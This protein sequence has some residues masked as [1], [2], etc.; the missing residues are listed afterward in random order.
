MDQT[1]LLI[2]CS[3]RYRSSPPDLHDI[4]QHGSDQNCKHDPQTPP[5]QVIRL[6]QGILSQDATGIATSPLAT[7]TAALAAYARL[8]APQLMATFKPVLND[9]SVALL[10]AEDPSNAAGAASLAALMKNFHFVVQVCVWLLA[11]LMKNFH[12]WAQVCLEVHSFSFE[13]SQTTTS[14]SLRI[15]EQLEKIRFCCCTFDVLT[16]E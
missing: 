6:Q 2:R 15:A 13:G 7:D 11:G 3:I 9:M 16:R 12:F 14:A 1:L 4:C 10:A 5:H 8:T